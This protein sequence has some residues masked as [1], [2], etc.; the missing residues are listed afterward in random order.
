MEHN[1]IQSKTKKN[2]FFLFQ[3]K[4]NRPLILL[5]F[6]LLVFDLLVTSSES[7]ALWEWQDFRKR[8]KRER[9]S[10]KFHLSDG[11]KD[12]TENEV[13]PIK[14]TPTLNV[15]S[16]DSPYALIDRFFPER[17][18]NRRFFNDNG[19]NLGNLPAS[20]VWLSDG[21]LLVLKGGTT[22]NRKAF[23]EPWSPLDD[24]VAPYREPKLPPP[25]FVPSDTGVGLP[26]P[27]EDEEVIEEPKSLTLVEERGQKDP[28]RTFLFDEEKLIARMENFHS[29]RRDELLNSIDVLKV[30]LVQGN[31]LN[32]IPEEP[33]RT[34]FAST[35]PLPDN[36]GYFAKTTPLPDNQGYF[37]NTTPLPDNQGFYVTTSTPNRYQSS[38]FIVHIV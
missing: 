32:S 26:L 1:V 4:R 5:L 2:I 19:T 38:G 30:N 8:H 15:S 28:F 23:D 29:K 36:L 6:L 10:K 31:T 27:Q 24:Y 21:D 35:T 11:T 14:E 13:E 20:D 17:E 37:A 25:D 3:M 16:K 12:I 22:P 34:Y 7:Y 9:Q 33:K 18:S